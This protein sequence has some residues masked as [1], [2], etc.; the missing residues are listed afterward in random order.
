MVAVSGN[1]HGVP[2]ATRRRVVEVQN[3]PGQVR[4]F[5]DGAMIAEHPVLEGRN[6]RRLDPSHRTAI[7][8]APEPPA[9]EPSQRPLDFYAAVGQRL[10]EA[11][12]PP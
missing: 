1:L 9:A 5:E 8:A 2:D 3:H 4:I 11:G 6:R 10:A 7:P 12:A